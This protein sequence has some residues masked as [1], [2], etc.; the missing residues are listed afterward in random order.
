MLG[1]DAS[2]DLDTNG[3]RIQLATAASNNVF[4]DAPGVKNA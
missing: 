1:I 2:I 3:W 4:H